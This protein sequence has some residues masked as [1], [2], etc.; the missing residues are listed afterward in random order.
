MSSTSEDSDSSRYSRSR[1]RR[2]REVEEVPEPV[3]QVNETPGRIH[4]VMQS[5]PPQ[6]GLTQP[7]HNSGR[8]QRDRLFRTQQVRRHRRHYQRYSARYQEAYDGSRTPLGRYA[9]PTP[10]EGPGSESEYSLDLGYQNPE[11]VPADTGKPVQPKAPNDT[12]GQIKLPKTHC[13]VLPSRYSDQHF[14]SLAS[15][16]TVEILKI[17]GERSYTQTSST[18]PSHHGN[19]E[20]RL[21][22]MF[23]WS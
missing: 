11:S 14:Q 5:P 18:E 15:L 21:P 19:H 13:S 3:V 7:Q 9:P 6:Y 10:A 23:R 4:V 17:D 22:E 20:S 12:C 16:I 8:Y 1:Y 2:A